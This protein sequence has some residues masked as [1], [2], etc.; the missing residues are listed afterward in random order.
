MG[1]AMIGAR[2]KP[3]IDLSRTAFMRPFKDLM[4]FGSWLWNND[5]EDHEP[6]LVILPSVRRTGIRPVVV[7]LS[8]AFKYDDAKYCLNA[9]RLFNRDLGFEDNIQN[10]TKVADAI[11]SHLS[12]LVSMPINPVEAVVGAHAVVNIGGKN[13]TVELMDY[14]PII[15]I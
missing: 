7:A 15:Q 13:Q 12:D 9:A 10:I 4:V 11:H 2:E 6:C 8:A 14:Q 1:E 5:Q 3:A